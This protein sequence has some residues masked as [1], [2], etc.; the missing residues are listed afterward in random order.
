[1]NIWKK[2]AQDCVEET[3]RAYDM[4]PKKIGPIAIPPKS[5]KIMPVRG[6]KC[7]RC[8]Q[9]R[10]HKNGPQ[11]VGR[12]C[13]IAAKKIKFVP[14]NNHKSKTGPQVSSSLDKEFKYKAPRAK[15]NGKIH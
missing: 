15:F 6:C 5:H 3:F 10:A 13:R 14:M 2:A 4:R 1:M 11:Q 12:P 7:W 9:C 8:E